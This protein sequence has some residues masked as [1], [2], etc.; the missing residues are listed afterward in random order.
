MSSNDQGG[1][2]DRD[3]DRDSDRG[4]R[5]RK[6]K[7]EPVDAYQAFMN[8]GREG[9]EGRDNAG[10]ELIF[11]EKGF[12]LFTTIFLKFIY[13]NPFFTTF[14]ITFYLCPSIYILDHFISFIFNIYSVG[15]EIRGARY[16]SDNNVF[17]NKN[18]PVESVQIT[19]LNEENEGHKLLKKMGW[20]EGKGLGADGSGILEPI[21]ETIKKDKTAG[22]GIERSSDKSDFSSYRNQLS[23]EYHERI[24]NEG[25]R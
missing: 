21:R 18:Q 11:L 12:Y 8:S 15:Y 1:D 25:R 6:G 2:R 22:L 16:S 14:T 13:F 7:N 19:S 10:G 5:D 9:R 4:D 24:G 20:S 3:R 23:S 17:Y